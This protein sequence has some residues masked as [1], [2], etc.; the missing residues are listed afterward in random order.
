MGPLP[1]ST[2][3]PSGTC[4]SISVRF[5]MSPELSLMPM[6]CSCSERRATVSGAIEMPVRSGML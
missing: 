4:R 2:M 3:K 5:A 6:I 1:V